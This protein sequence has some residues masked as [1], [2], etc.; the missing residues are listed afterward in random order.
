MPDWA[1]TAVWPKIM[2]AKLNI[3]KPPF[4]L[5]PAKSCPPNLQSRP[6]RRLFGQALEKRQLLFEIAYRI[7]GN[8][9]DAEDMVQE[10]FLRW[11]KIDPSEIKSVEAWLPTVITSPRANAEQAESLSIAFLAILETLSSTERAV[12]L[13]VELAAFFSIRAASNLL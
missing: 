8:V 6:S 3:P 13:L 5:P 9:A 12:Y 2:N 1:A 7:L 4:T 10:T 11:Q